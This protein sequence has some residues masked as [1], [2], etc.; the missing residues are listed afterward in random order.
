MRMDN[1]SLILSTLDAHLSHPFRLVL[2][3]RAALQ[4]GF[5][6][7]P[8]EVAESKDVD[9]T[10]PLADLETLSSNEGFWD[11]QEATN[12]ELRPKGLYI[13]HLFRADQVFLRRDWEEHLIP[14]TRLPMRWLRLFR[15]ATLD[16]VL[17]KMMRGDDPQ[18]MADI[19]FMIRH[20]RVTPDQVESAIADAVNPVRL[21]IPRAHRIEPGL[22][23]LIRVAPCKIHGAAP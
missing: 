16:L 5:T 9:A 11:A 15:P 2:Y 8:P 20:D 12:N 7:A 6:A 3:G 1:A 14:I 10:I 23:Q 13:T 22:H 21:S 18:D 4:L 19:A 17:T